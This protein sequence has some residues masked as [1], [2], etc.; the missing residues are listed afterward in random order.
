MIDDIA[1]DNEGPDG[2][3]LVLTG[4]FVEQVTAYL[5]DRDATRLRLRLTPATQRQLDAALQPFREHWAEGEAIRQQVEAHRAAGMCMEWVTSY[6]PCTLDAHH[7]GPCYP[8]GG[9][10]TE[11]EQVDALNAAGRRQDE[12]EAEKRL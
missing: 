2:D 7:E 6:G 4:D 10:V 5:E 12:W 11:E 1:I 3:W 8:E 9:F